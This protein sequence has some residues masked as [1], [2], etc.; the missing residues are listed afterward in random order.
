ME[1]VVVGLMSDTDTIKMDALVTTTISSPIKM[2]VNRKWLRQPHLDELTLADTYYEDDVI[3]VDILIGCDYYGTFMT[4][5]IIRKGNIMAMG[6]VFG[7]LL[8]GPISKQ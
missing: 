5:N 3:D 4:G 2:Q 8:S 7:W 1:V 6:S